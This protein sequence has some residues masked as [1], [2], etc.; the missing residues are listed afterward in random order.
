M[1]PDQA[2]ID[3]SRF[4]AE[5]W[6]EGDLRFCSHGSNR[7]YTTA[8]SGTTVHSRPFRELTPNPALSSPQV[9]LV[10][11]AQT[12]GVCIGPAARTTKQ[13]SD[14]HVGIF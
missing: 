3:S 12:C 13:V 14:A 5:I 11:P 9:R 10:Q 4:G 1:Q 2:F 7:D 6:G 8:G